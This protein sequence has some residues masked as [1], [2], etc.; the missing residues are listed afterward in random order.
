VPL[1]ILRLQNVY[2]PGQAV[3]NSYTG[4]LTFFARQLASSEQVEVYEDGNIVR[5]FVYVDDVISAVGAAM[6]RPPSNTRLVDIGGGRPVT[7]MEVA[8]TMCEIVDGRLPI[9]NG[10]YRLG[11]VR[12]ASADVTAAHAE[13]DWRPGT[14]LSDGL[15]ALL[16]WVPSQL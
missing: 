5:D 9:V 1:T 14:S 10:Q 15:A 6:R 11:D 2:G 16:A 12:A 4:V 13:L 3:G 7:L 8:T